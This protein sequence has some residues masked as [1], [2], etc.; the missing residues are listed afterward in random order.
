[1]SNENNTS[2]SID[3]LRMYFKK[4]KSESYPITDHP[5]EQAD[6]YSKGIYITMLCTIMCNNSVP[7]EE[8]ILFIERLMKGIGIAGTINDYIK[9]ALEIND[10]FAEDFIRQFKDNEL[11]YNFVVDTLILISSVGSPAKRDMEFVSEICDILA[12]EKNKLSEILR[13]ATIILEQNNEEYKEF[14]SMELSIDI[15]R[16]FFYI[17]DFSQGLLSNNSKLFYARFVNTDSLRNEKRFA[18]LESISSKK[19]ILENILFDGF[20]KL[21][22]LN[23]CGEILINKCTF[24]NNI[25]NLTCSESENITIIDCNFKEL[26]NRALYLSE[27]GNMEIEG[28]NFE[29][30]SFESHDDGSYG[31]KDCAYGGAIYIRNAKSLKV[32]GCNFIKCKTEHYKDGNADGAIAYLFGIN[33]FKLENC[34]FDFCKNSYFRYSWRECGG[35]FK[36]ENTE[37]DKAINCTTKNCVSVGEWRIGDF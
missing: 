30:C 35:L 17:I 9:K 32:D 25:K 8:Q 12:I 16:F 19:V 15:S 1:M 37:C 34:Q 31:Y 24:K 4:H 36:V 6:E 33:N 5:L 14:C 11:K 20:E 22:S 23:N 13:L 18:D 26:K 29:K 28:C 21:P 2:K 27:C 10:K 7:R 3:K